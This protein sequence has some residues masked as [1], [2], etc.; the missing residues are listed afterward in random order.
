MRE[1]KRI[2]LAAALLAI[3]PSSVFAQA[4]LAGTVRD[5]SG[6]VLPGVTVEAAS[7]VL[8]EKVRS[9]VT[10]G[11]GQYRLTELLP[12]TY[13]VTF[14]LTGFNT[15]KREAVEL[16]GVAVTTINAELRVGSIQETITVTGETP[17]V[18]VQSARRGQVLNNETIANLPATRG[19]NAIVAMVPSVNDGSTQQIAIIPAMRIFYSHGGRGNEGRVQVDGLNVGASFNGGGVSGFI[20]DTSNAAEL[21][22]TLSG[23]LGEAE[24]GGTNVNIIPKT[25]GNSFSG[26]FFTSNAGE[27]SQGANLDDRLKGLGLTA[28]AKLY[29]NYDIS[30]AVGGPIKRDRLWFFANA[31]T[32][33][34]ME[35]IPGMFANKNAGDATKWTYERNPDIEARNAISQRIVSLRLTAQITPRNKIG[36]YIDNQFVCSGSSATPTAQSCRPAGSNWIANGAGAIAPEA[37]SGAQGAIQGAAGYADSYQRVTQATWTSPVTNKLLF[38]AG[39]STY[40][41]RWG[42]MQPP[43][44]ITNINQVTEQASLNGAPANLTYRALDWNFNNWQS[45]TVW[46]ASASYVTGAH[47]MKFGYQGA[48]HITNTDSFYNQTRVNYTLN[49][50]APVSLLMNIGNWETSDRTQYNAFYVQDQ[51][52]MGRWTVQGALRYDRAWSWAP[53]EHNGAVDGGDRFH[54]T[55]IT[56]PY[57][58]GVDAYN[59]I[60]AR[61]GVAWDVRGN[62]KTSLKVNLGKYLQSANNQDSYTF[63]SPAQ[64]TRFQRTTARTWNDRGGLGINGDYVPQCDLMNPAANGECGPW[65]SPTFGNP[66]SP[67]EINPAILR[68]WGVRPN[69]SQFGVSIQHEVAPR[70]SV[71]FGYHRRW[72][73]NFFVTDNRAVSASDFSRFTVTAP[74]H[75][76]LPGGGG[77]QVTYYD[78]VRLTVNNYLTFETDYAPAR[79]QYWH[80]FDVNFN[81]RLRN[82]LNFQGGTSTGRGVRDYCALA[83][84]L[85]E[86]VATVAGAR[87]P[88]GFCSVTEP[89]L[90]Q[91][92]GTASYVVPKL[93]VL[94]SL[95]IQSKP[96]TLGIGGNDSATNGLSLNSNAPTL[97]S[98]IA[99]S[100][101]RLPTGQTNPAG[102]TS[103]NVLLPGQLYGDRVNQLD[104]R[105]G[106]ILRFGRTRTTVGVDLYNILNSNPGL[107]YNQAF[108][109]NWPRPTA[110][111]MPRFVRFNATVDF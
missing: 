15:F 90:T 38:E 50:T 76:E 86:L 91:F 10:D 4:T 65:L 44:A 39:W 108:A 19:Y 23:G 111:L 54:P 29:K 40:V 16:A 100:L 101:G 47:N 59:D 48:Y 69:D 9:T 32:F 21:N 66:V 56:F 33:G 98:V 36:Y 68:G 109:A 104:L 17:I 20:M 107:V 24:V 11:T 6:G 88:V 52:T 2:L 83:A 97:N 58:A 43:G 13:T 63:N 96:G 64:A 60:T 14:T 85:P 12:G 81:T 42:W 37:A 25:G 41:S 102:T 34:T 93:D 78:P 55:T 51:W 77:Y 99:Q 87:Q 106:K 75:P 22:L 3:L 26:T 94:L 45:P 72:F 80:G 89:F 110:I 92:R 5:A 7:P 49:N 105:V 71:E 8:I 62:G 103:L 27:W 73:G 35:N 84:V 82:G 67:V 70:T 30:Q 18:D 53:A 61:V 74:S 46:R 28:S 31:R 1:L 57:T 95:G 79:T